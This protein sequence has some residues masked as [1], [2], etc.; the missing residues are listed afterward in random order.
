MLIQSLLVYSLLIMTMMLCAIIASSEGKKKLT[1]NNLT[2]KLSFWRFEVI[3]PLLLFALVFGM[4]YDVGVDYL[5]YLNGYLSKIQVG[6]NEPLFYLLSEIGWKFNLHY[7]VY[8]TAI[9][10]IQI[11]FF[12]YAFKDE[13]FLFPFLVFFLF[14][15]GF[16]SFWMNGMRQAIAICI[17][18]YSLKHI[19]EKKPLKYMI[20]GIVAFLFHRSA[21]VLLIFYPILQNG[22]QY[23]KNVKLQLIL[24][25]ISFV[26][27]NIFFDVIMK[28]ESM[29][30]LYTNLLGAEMYENY[31]LDK[32]LLSFSDNAGTGV[33]FLFKLFL[34]IIIILNSKKLFTFYNNRKFNVVYFF[35]FL[36]L[37]TRYMFPENAI[38][39]TRPFQYFYIFQTIM[40]AYFSYYLF[41]I[42]NKKTINWILF[43]GIIILF[44]GIFYLSQFTSDV[45]SHLWY[46]FYFFQNINGYPN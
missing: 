15:D 21:I 9:A 3:F 12:F 13:R 38:S 23:F 1:E 10:F 27:K 16:W 44:V 30:M 8:F 45:N 32:L 42:R 28:L 34:N 29:I 26:I 11:F 37:L 41:K 7:V 31:N 6:K 24:I 17:W 5:N 33:A 14:T 22:K 19:V 18:I 40:Y 20:W 4:R 2:T 36:G 35:F 46:Q 39:F 43:Y 25:L